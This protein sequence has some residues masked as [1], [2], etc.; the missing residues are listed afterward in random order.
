MP[1][2][3]QQNNGNHTGDMAR[4][5]A[6]YAGRVTVGGNGPV[7]LSVWKRD[8]AMQRAQANGQSIAGTDLRP[9][10]GGNAKKK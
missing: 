4:D 1:D 9:E 6:K 7:D 8:P 3:S 10:R 2:T 5:A